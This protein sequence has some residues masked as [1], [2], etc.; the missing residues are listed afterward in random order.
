MGILN[1]ENEANNGNVE[2]LVK[3]GRIYLEGMGVEPD[4]KK[5]HNYFVKA[6]KEQNAAAYSYLAY[7]YANGLGV[8]KND[9]KVVSYYQKAY[10]LN[11]VYASLALC[12][13][14]RRGLYG[15]DKDEKQALEYIT[16]ASN[17]GF[18]PAKYEHAFLLEKQA[19]KLQASEDAQDKQKAKTLSDQAMTLYREASQKGYAPAK[20]ALAIKYIDSNDAQKNKDIFTLLD[21]AKESGAPYVY[22]ALAYAY[23]FGI[24]C[25]VNYA[26]SF[27]YL[28]KAYDAGY[29][30]AGMDIAYAYLLGAGCPQDYKKALDL[31]REAVNGGIQE[32]NFYAGMC[33]EY[34]LS[35]DADIQ[36]AIELYGYAEQ[37]EYVPAI[38][39]LGQIYDPYYKLGADADGAKEEYE[40][41]AAKG[42]ID[43]QAELAKMNFEND[44]KTEFDKLKKFADQG[45]AVAL[46]FLGKLYK[47]GNGVNQSNDKALDYFKKAADK[48]MLF[49]AKEA[50]E[51]AEEKNDK[52]TLSKYGDMLNGFGSPKAYFARARE[53]EDLGDADRAVYWYSMAG[54]T[55]K[56][57]ENTDRAEGAIKEGFEKGQNGTWSKK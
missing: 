40:S 24:G 18:G 8:E 3:L 43:A 50:I 39:K 57:Q 42:S 19:K 12:I 28:N 35:V 47:D 30:K 51:I 17:T 54:L 21:A 25:N 33:F 20:Y 55:T 56:K 45:S 41:A 29:K 13:I 6:A 16:R 26:K 2:A 9:E 36:K 38:L 1:I 5:A 14:S 49:A 23:D 10:E 32:A 15:Q 27:E 34:G 4:Y 53:L 7:T 52:A 44:K 31:L 37:A 48:G 22:Y 46:E 11:D